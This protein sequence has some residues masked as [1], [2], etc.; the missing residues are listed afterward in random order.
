MVHLPFP[1]AAFDA[2]LAFESL[3]HAGPDHH[4][5]DRV[6][7]ALAEIDRVLRPGGAPLYEDFVRTDRLRSWRT[8]HRY[9][10]GA[11]VRCH[12]HDGVIARTP[13]GSARGTTA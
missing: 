10:I 6:R 3:H 5:F 1:P 8:D 4:D 13:F 12:R 7:D 9:A 2:V 11:V